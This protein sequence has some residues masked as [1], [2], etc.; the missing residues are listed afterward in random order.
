VASHM[1]PQNVSNTAYAFAA[2]GRMPGAETRAALEAAVVR[3]ALDP[4]VKPQAV[5]N[6][7]WAFATLGWEPGAEVRAALKAAVVR[8][9]ARGCAHES[10]GGD[11]RCVEFRDARL[12]AGG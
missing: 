10:P 8:V 2:L 4:D 11:E 3:V 9:A 12:G 7:T 1:N 5:T 6:V